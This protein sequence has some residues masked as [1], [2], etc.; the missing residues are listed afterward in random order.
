MSDEAMRKLVKLSEELGLY[1]MPPEVCLTHKRHIPCRPGMREGGCVFST[2][3][4]DVQM[5]RDYQKVRHESLSLRSHQ[6][7]H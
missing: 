2:A 1:D 6:R 5:V 4:E 7:L 3:S